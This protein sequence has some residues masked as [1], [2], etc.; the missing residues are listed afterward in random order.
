[1]YVS[2]FWFDTGLVSQH[3]DDSS[4][5]FVKRFKCFYIV[6]KPN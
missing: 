3:L 4:D 1:M 6:F 5:N 2:N